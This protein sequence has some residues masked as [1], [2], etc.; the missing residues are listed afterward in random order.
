[1]TDAL[2]CREAFNRLEEF[3]DRE[4][5]P[6]ETV[7]VQAHLEQCVQCAREFRF[8]AG[9]LEGIRAKLAHIG[10]PQQ[11]A[12]RVSLALRAGTRRG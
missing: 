6:E 11:L 12:E 7:Q 1:M 5:S 2:T 10:I 9:V 8:E 3:L 4:L